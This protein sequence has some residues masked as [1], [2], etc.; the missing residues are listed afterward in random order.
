MDEY[1]NKNIITIFSQRLAGYLMYNGFVVGGMRPD[2]DKSGRNVFFFKN[3]ENLR[4]TIER[5][6]RLH[7]NDRH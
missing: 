1:L 3:S 2:D 7:P 6:R 4:N 5:Y